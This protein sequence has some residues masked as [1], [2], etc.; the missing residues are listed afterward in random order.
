MK[1]Y[2]ISLH[3]Q[4][5][6]EAPLSL[7]LTDISNGISVDYSV[8]LMK[9]N[10]DDFEH[11]FRLN[12][13]DYPESDIRISVYYDE[14]ENL[15]EKLNLI[16]QFISENEAIINRDEIEV[17][18]DTVE[19]AD[20]ENE[21]KK[22]FHSFRVSESFV[23]VPSWEMDDYEYDA[24][25]RL[26]K[27]DPGMAFGTGDHPTTSMCLTFIEKI[28]RPEHKVIDVGTGSGILTIGAYLM[29]A[30]DL[31]ATDIDT[32]SLTVAEENFNLNDTKPVDLRAADL[33]K[34]E[35]KN[36]DIVVANIL[37]HVIEDMITDSYRVLNDGGYFISS[38]IIVEK[39]ED[40]L[41][42]LKNSGFN[43][44]EVLEDD[45]WAS[46]LSKKG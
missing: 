24:N 37:A 18:V 43:I 34:N 21:W 25:D 13:S 8:D 14:T 33:L 23:I 38:G 46:I 10:I 7:F 1:W 3:S 45:G 4:I 29:G 36:Y 41:S 12:E 6:N 26:I 20:W 11:K 16:N 15:D 42:Q 30:R 19:E 44:I 28:I 32:L 2:K 5:E 39:K 27:L 40:I 35:T 17:T 9:S 22:Y 31:T